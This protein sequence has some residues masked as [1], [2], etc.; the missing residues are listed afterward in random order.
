MDGQRFLTRTSIREW[1]GLLALV[2]GTLFCGLGSAR[3]WD[4]DEPRNARCAQEMLE[5]S[6]WIVPTFDGELRTHK[7]ILLYWLQLTSYQIFGVHEWSARLPSVL[8]GLIAV[9]ACYGMATHLFNRRVGVWG[10]IC[11]STSVMFIVAS[12]A[13]T[14]DAPL[15]ACC[16]VTLWLFL[17]SAYSRQP[18]GELRFQQPKWI[19]WFSIY[20]VCAIAILAKGPVGLLLPGMVMGLQLMWQTWPTSVTQTNGLWNKG[21]RGSITFVRHACIT[22]WRMRP[23]SAMFAVLVI[24]SPW[25]IMVGLA[26][27]GVWLREFFWTH[28]VSRAVSTMEGHSG[29]PILFYLATLCVGTFPWSIWLGPAY[30]YAYRLWQTQPAWRPGLMFCMTWTLVYIVSFSFAAT[31]LPSYVTPCY[32]AVVM[33][34]AGLFAHWSQHQKV[35]LKLGQVG[36]FIGA[37][38]FL[39]L[40]LLFGQ[41]R[42]NDQL[43][44]AV[45][46]PVGAIAT[47]CACGAL[48]LMSRSHPRLGLQIYTSGAIILII[49]LASFGSERVDTCRGDLALLTTAMQSRDASKLALIGEVEPSWVFY[50]K[51]SAT[52]I[53]IAG[54]ERPAWDFLCADTQHQLLLRVEQASELERYLREL[55]PSAKF[56]MSLPPKPALNGDRYVLIRRI[57]PAFPQDR[58]S[59]IRQARILEGTSTR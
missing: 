3:L 51:G 30:W 42:I 37:M 23:F 48:F 28:N 26:T 34:Y 22:A 12:R 11:L 25:Y 43:P 36:L 6:D 14:P 24:A 13:A 17:R 55:D 59:E 8:C 31:K 32:P 39:T 7:P 47:I 46:V 40:T 21:L 1:V 2:L 4:R 44:L 18:S 41:F 33:V 57:H 35:C 10:A 45:L 27:D 50:T 15:I 53:P 52:R 58:Q 54:W 29:P 56:E 20:I 38:V 16:T 5:R 9:L 49:A 19:D